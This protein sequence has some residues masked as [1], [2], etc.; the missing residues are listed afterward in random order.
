M[1]ERKKTLSG[2][3]SYREDQED[4]RRLTK[5]EHRCE[6]KL[7]FCLIKDNVFF[8]P[9]LFYYFYPPV[10][11]HKYIIAPFPLTPSSPYGQ[12]PHVFP[13]P[14]SPLP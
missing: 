3:I 9:I 8:V 4:F 11:L 1:S 12:L 10:L 6:E 5:S 2:K 7:C 13:K 14:L